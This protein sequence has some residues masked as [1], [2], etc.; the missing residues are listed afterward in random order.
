MEQLRADRM[1][2]ILMLLQNEGKLSAKQLAEKLEVSERT[3]IR[4]LEALSISGV[5]VYA[6]RGS[7]GGWR[8]A[9]GYR[10]QLT[11]MKAEEFISL[12]VSAHPGLLADL[13]IKQHFDA[14][15]Q[16]LLA[17]SPVSIKKN[18][19]LLQ[20]KIH[21]DGASWHGTNESSPHLTTIQ[22][23]MLT[24]HK[25]C[26]HYK[27]EQELTARIVHPLG[28]VAKRSVWYLITEMEGEL[29]TYRI[30]KIVFAEMM[31]ESFPY[32]T[33]FNLA[34]YW[35]QSTAQFKHNLPRYP[36][37][38][39]IK[40]HLLHRLEQERYIQMIH[41]EKSEEGWLEA[42]VAFATLDHG[43]ETILSY[44]AS[45]EALTPAELR[46]KVMT[47]TKAVLNLYSSGSR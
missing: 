14:A 6:E 5:P 22:E 47:E 7:G 35:E 18:V 42:T 25:L 17:S 10:T 40:E 3:I 13:G 21:I 33:E 9:E 15:Y 37:K 8:L 24:E 20:R 1:L 31:D 12:I 32:P 4:D 27:K 11:G 43:S 2:S 36:A 16:K 19:E 46:S 28:L 41:V 34:R 29:R 38:I 39:K 26:I 44:G 45:A 23:A 30:S